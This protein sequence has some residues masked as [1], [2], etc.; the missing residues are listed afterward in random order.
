MPNPATRISRVSRRALL[1]IASLLFLAGLLLEV[2]H[3]APPVSNGPT[4]AAIRKVLDN[5]V[6]A[7]NRVDIAT[8]M[9][10]YDNAPTT[11]FVGKSVEHGYANVLARYQKSFD[12][13]E[14]M[15]TLNFTD[16][17]IT[18]VDPQV[19]AVTGHYHL[20]RS[21]AGGGD[22]QGIFSLVFKKTAAGWKI[23]LD[24]TS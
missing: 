2:G 7:W 12:S 3:S 22:A 6:K 23:V 8:F 10:G 15:G 16:L 18:P 13:K 5:Q 11:T 1:H 20:K 19:A 4:Q 17:E 24:H 21:A 9:Q 14:K